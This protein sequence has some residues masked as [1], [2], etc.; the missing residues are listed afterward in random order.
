MQPY[1]EVF[2]RRDSDKAKTM[3]VR[4]TPAP[5]WSFGTKMLSQ[6]D[7]AQNPQHWSFQDATKKFS[8]TS[9]ENP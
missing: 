6:M 9:S 1:T 5:N 4:S 8:Y 3:Q 2:D 7:G